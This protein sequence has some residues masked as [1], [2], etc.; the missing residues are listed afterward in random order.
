MSNYEVNGLLR[1]PATPGM[2]SGKKM[3]RQTPF[4]DRTNGK[5]FSFAFSSSLTQKTGM[6]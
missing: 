5:L 3:A 6:I 1:P 2:G 4:E